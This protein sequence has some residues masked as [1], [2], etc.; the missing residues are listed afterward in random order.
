M[1]KPSKAMVTAS[2]WYAKLAS[3]EASERDYAAWQSWKDANNEHAKAWQQLEEINQQF[4]QL[5]KEVGLSTLQRPV[6]PRR[7]AFKQLVVMV[8]VGTASWYAYREQPWREVL[9]D[10]KTAV[11]ET[12]EVQLADGTQLYMN[13]DT[14]INVQ[15]NNQQRQIELVEGEVL[16]KTGH[17]DTVQRNFTVKTQH[18]L[19]TALGTHFSVRNFADHTKAS[20]FEGQIKVEPSGNLGQSIVLNAG[21]SVS[22][23]NQQLSSTE[24]A[25]FTDVAWSKGILVAYA[26]PL[27]QFA[28]ELSRYRP[29]VLRCD[30]AVAKFEISGSFPTQDTD[31]ALNILTNTLPLRVRSVTRFW[32]N[33]QAI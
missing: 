27:S 9:A 8:G 5:P 13:T 22:F 25:R 16:I 29:G 28:A 11:G 26:M 12:R 19:V 17:N 2:Q 21:E 32:T 30:P 23:T 1:L 10:Y 14:A 33:I 15:Y 20:L 18:G 24:K 4:Q 3:G 6:L 7:Q 31:A